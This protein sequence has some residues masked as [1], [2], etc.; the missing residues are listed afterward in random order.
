[1]IRPILKF[2]DSILHGKAQAVDG[3]TA[4]VVRLIDDMIETMYA[5]PGVGLAA[6]QI[7]VALRIFV[8]DVSVGRDPEG[9]IVRVN[10]VS[11]KAS[12]CSRA[13][14]STRWIT[15]TARCSSTGCAASSAS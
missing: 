10:R 2:G 8:V 6:T 3:L 15:S 5:A 1:L 12:A 13:H 14:F 9:L 7:G 11:T 4:D